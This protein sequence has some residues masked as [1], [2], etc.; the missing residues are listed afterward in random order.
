MSIVF[1]KQCRVKFST[2][3]CHTKGTVNYFH[4]DLWRPQKFS[5]RV[6]LGILRV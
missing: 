4:S 5:P 1:G 3:V 6:V 2:A